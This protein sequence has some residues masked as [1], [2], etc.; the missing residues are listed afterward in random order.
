MVLVGKMLKII[1]LRTN[2]VVGRL[3][4]NMRLG[5][6]G[7][8]EEKQLDGKEMYVLDII[9]KKHRRDDVRHGNK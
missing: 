1:K 6:V 3:V 8:G 2:T 5:E 7:V 4:C 9:V